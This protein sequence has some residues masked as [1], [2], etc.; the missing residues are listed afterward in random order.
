VSLDALLRQR[1]K[2]MDALLQASERKARQSVLELEE[3]RRRA[4][5]V[6]SQWGQWGV[7]CVSLMLL[8][9]LCRAEPHNCTARWATWCACTACIPV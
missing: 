7:R 8:I 9:A 6:R 3:Q 1:D 4:D 5:E 2:E